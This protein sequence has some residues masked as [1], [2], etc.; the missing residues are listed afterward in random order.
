MTPSGAIH[1]PPF[2]LDSIEEQLWRGK[3]KLILQRRPFAVLSY[4]LRHPGN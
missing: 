1:F 4:L 3:Q 2:R